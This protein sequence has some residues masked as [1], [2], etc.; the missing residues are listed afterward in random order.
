MFKTKQ[1]RAQ[2]AKY[3][4]LGQNADGHD[5]ARIFRQLE[6]KYATLANNEQL[7]AESTH[8]VTAALSG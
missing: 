7:L 3:R 5:Q 2:A 1:F 4:N 8:P 6:Q